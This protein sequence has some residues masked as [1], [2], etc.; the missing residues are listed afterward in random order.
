MFDSAHANVYTAHM[1][2]A[3][4]FLLLFLLALPAAARAQGDA[5]SSAI[6]IVENFQKEANILMRSSGL[7]EVPDFP[8]N[9]AIRDLEDI[10]RTEPPGVRRSERVYSIVNSFT[11]DVIGQA[12]SRGMALMGP[13][14]ARHADS[15]RRL[16]DLRSE[17]LDRLRERLSAEMPQ[18]TEPEGVP[19]MDISPYDEERQLPDGPPGILFR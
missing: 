14:R 18:K 10:R 19:S 11:Q 13:E 16:R 12:E 15:I 4:L 17:S 1:S 3:V 2:R 9:M 7:F 5:V 8:R 6:N